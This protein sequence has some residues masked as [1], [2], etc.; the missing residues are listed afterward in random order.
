MIDINIAARR[1]N[2]MKF[3][4]A[5]NRAILPGKVAITARPLEE[6]V[7]FLFNLIRRFNMKNFHFLSLAAVVALAV[8]PVISQGQTAASPVPPTA[9]A[10][11]ADCGKTTMKRHDHGAERGAGSTAGSMQMNKPCPSDGSASAAK[12]TTKKVQRHDHAKSKNL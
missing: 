9:A 11:P 5:T 1:P 2:T 10:K 3:R 8:A 4:Q 7:P 12:S 6:T